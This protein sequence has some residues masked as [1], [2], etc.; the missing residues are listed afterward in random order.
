MSLL[1]PLANMMGG[2]APAPTPQ[3]PQTKFHDVTVVKRKTVGRARVQG[4]PPE[5]CC[6]ERQA[7]SIRDCGYFFH[8]V[9][10][11]RGALID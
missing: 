11:R 6:I 3:L 4:V 10:R 9:T 8:R 2:A 1:A 7:R 5:E